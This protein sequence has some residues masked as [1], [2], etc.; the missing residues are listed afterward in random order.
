[1]VDL[2]LP[3]IP[4]TMFT[5]FCYNCHVNIKTIFLKTQL[6]KSTLPNVLQ[7]FVA[8]AAEEKCCRCHRPATTFFI[9]SEIQE[10]N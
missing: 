10:S 1:M 9:K 5:D 7:G 2:L 4:A 3:D 8:F 6:C